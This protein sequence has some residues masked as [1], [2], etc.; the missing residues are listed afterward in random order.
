MDY[1][2]LGRSTLVLT[3]HQFVH[4]DALCFLN[5]RRTRSHHAFNRA[6]GGPDTMEA[7]RVLLDIAICTSKNTAASFAPGSL[8]EEN[9]CYERPESSSGEVTVLCDDSR[10]AAKAELRR[11]LENR[12]RAYRAYVCMHSTT[13]ANILL[14]L[15]TEQLQHPAADA[16][17]KVENENCNLVEPVLRRCCGTCSGLVPEARALLLRQMICRE[18]LQYFSTS[19]LKASTCRPDIIESFVGRSSEAMGLETTLDFGRPRVRR[20]I[21]PQTCLFTLQI[22]KWR[23]V[24]NHIRGKKLI[25]SDS[26]IFSHVAPSATSCRISC[27][28]QHTT[29]RNK[30]WPMYGYGMIPHTSPP[31]SEPRDKST[32]H[33]VARQ[34]KQ[35]SCLEYSSFDG[36]GWALKTHGV[37]ANPCGAGLPWKLTKLRSVSTHHERSP[38]FSR[39]ASYRRTCSMPENGILSHN[40]ELCD[41]LPWDRPRVYALAR[42]ETRLPR[43][44][45][46][47]LNCPQQRATSKPKG[48]T[49]GCPINLGL[50][51][52]IHHCFHDL[53]IGRF[54]AALLRP[55]H[56]L[57]TFIETRK[58]FEKK[59]TEYSSIEGKLD[60]GIFTVNDVPK[61]KLEDLE[62]LPFCIC[63]EQ[64]FIVWVYIAGF[65]RVIFCEDLPEKFRCCESLF[66]VKADLVPTKAP[67]WPEQEAINHSPL[68]LYTRIFR[69]NSQAS[70]LRRATSCLKPILYFRMQGRDFACMNSSSPAGH[71]T[72]F[73]SNFFSRYHIGGKP[74][75]STP[76]ATSYW[77]LDALSRET[78]QHAILLTI[79][80]ADLNVG[81][82]ST[83]SFTP[84]GSTYFLAS[85]GHE[86]GDAVA[87]TESGESS[88]DDTLIIN[89]RSILYQ[90]QAKILRNLCGSMMKSD[91]PVPKTQAM[92]LKSPR[93]TPNR[94]LDRLSGFSVARRL[95]PTLSIWVTISVYSVGQEKLTHIS[96]FLTSLP[97]VQPALPLGSNSPS[98]NFSPNLD[99][100]LRKLGAGPWKDYSLIERDKCL[101]TIWPIATTPTTSCLID[102]KDVAVVCFQWHA[103]H[104][105]GFANSS[106]R[107]MD[108][109]CLLCQPTR[110]GNIPKIQM[111]THMVYGLGVSHKQHGHHGDKKCSILWPKQPWE[112]TSDVEY[113]NHLY[114]L[115]VKDII[116]E[117]FPSVFLQED[118]SFV[119]H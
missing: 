40:E 102:S 111:N 19:F 101:L 59:R 97:T 18:H 63:P 93:E 29:L 12:Y 79:Q 91:C 70:L 65:D 88:S 108:S 41:N 2:G 50:G 3:M 10:L 46:L 39:A 107:S 67:F 34:T 96:I 47:F 51:S 52:T 72:E 21:Q 78:F 103:L 81:L 94:Y 17:R 49:M 60:K 68:G 28:K 45:R 105:F 22:T 62:I 98:Q 4:F 87:T 82:T 86:L 36:E 6:G 15:S 48:S 54:Y 31:I 23:I 33:S 92:S 90:R 25:C 110:I 27:P 26:S 118:V 71:Q 5:V 69:Q 24:V 75:I 113:P 73:P 1:V 57:Q 8:F 109:G 53:A 74:A 116:F 20:K 55:A 9:N 80:K 30:N 117:Q 83:L 112:D 100:E 115:R 32:L 114:K 56:A 89:L 95:H 35:K 119:T 7:H 77:V 85:K 38:K 37:D 14:L 76:I 16:Q 106:I 58:W 43:C 11:V 42:N 44:A 84:K 64:D 66:S 104:D 99:D 13:L 61:P